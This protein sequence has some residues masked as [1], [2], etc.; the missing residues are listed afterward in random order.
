MDKFLL[1]IFIAC[2]AIFISF[3]GYIF[4][5]EK[6]D[7]KIA[8]P[9]PDFLTSLQN[10]QV[11]TLSL[12]EPILS[13]FEDSATE[14]PELTARSVLVYDL[15]EDKALFEKNIKQ[16]VPIASLTKIMTAVVALEHPKKDD[17]YFVTRPDL[18]GENS[19]GLSA[20]E[21]LSLNDLLYGLILRSGNDA[22]E[23]IAGNYPG[24]RTA[25]IRAMNDKA[26]ALGLKNTNFTNPSGLEG[27][28]D[29]YSTAQDLLVITRY[30]LSNLPT[31]SH[32]VSTV[33]YHI[34][35]TENHAEYFLENETNLLTSYPGVKG[36]KT[37]YTPEA[38]YCLVTY[39]D[40]GGHR[41]IG[42]ILGSENRRQEMKDLLD[43]SLKTLGVEPPEHD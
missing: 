33:S 40:Y 25:F 14:K 30:A 16:K 28:G 21:V 23:T 31:F 36:V 24:G 1:P 18:V 17:K 35:Q 34:P 11:T 9:L 15:S 13:F 22:T 19:M 29:Q 20:G 32:V 41:I 27:D 26:K 38:G 3:T 4:L 43:Y 8:S 12:W 6:K 2:I 5:N 7:T 42:I 37:G 10:K 39:L